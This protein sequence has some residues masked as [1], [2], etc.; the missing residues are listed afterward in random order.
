MSLRLAFLVSAALLSSGC[1]VTSELGKPCVLVKASSTGQGSEPVTL[2]D[3]QPGQDFVSFGSLDCEDLICV[4]DAKSERQTTQDGKV[5]GYCSRPC[6]ATLQ[7]NCAVTDESVSAELRNRMTCRALLLDQAALDKLRA[8]D[9]AR[10]RQIFG[11]HNS[12]YFCSGQ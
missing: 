7:D 4:L 9:P 11:D 10:Y 2:S 8:D 6:V 12:P 1:E 3:L 5:L